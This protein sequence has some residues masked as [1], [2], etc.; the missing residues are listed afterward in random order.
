MQVAGS[1]S[2]KRKELAPQTASGQPILCPRKVYPNSMEEFQSCLCRVLC[3]ET[4]MGMKGYCL[5]SLLRTFFSDSELTK[6]KCIYSEDASRNPFE[7]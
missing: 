4:A 7:H 2:P 6:V 5:S 1:F 3:G